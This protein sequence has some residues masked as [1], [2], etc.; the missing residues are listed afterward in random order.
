MNED[1]ISRWD[2]DTLYD[3]NA[4]KRVSDAFA[5]NYKE[6]NTVLTIKGGYIATNKYDPRVEIDKN[7]KINPEL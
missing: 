4:C 6:Y 1:V 5:K 3:Y 7:S 2:T